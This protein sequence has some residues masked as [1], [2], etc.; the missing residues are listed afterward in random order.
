MVVVGVGEGLLH[1]QPLIPHR[2]IHEPDN[3]QRRP[4][5]DQQQGDQR[6][7]ALLFFRDSHAVELTS[8]AR[9][10]DAPTSLRTLEYSAR[11]WTAAM[12]S[13]QSPL[14]LRHS[15]VRMDL[16]YSAGERQSGDCADF[17]T[18]V[19]DANARYSLHPQDR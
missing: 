9:I 1:S 15:Q 4:Q 5:N 18:A 6:P 16:R 2:H 7:C 13:A 19:Q 10:Q 8:V 14:W 3:A 11:F 17:V 12:E